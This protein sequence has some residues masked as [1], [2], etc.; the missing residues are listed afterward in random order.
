MIISKKRAL[1]CVTHHR[2][3]CSEYRLQEAEQALRI[4]RTWGAFDEE[5]KWPAGPALK[6]S[7]VIELC[8]K[9]LRCLRQE[10]FDFRK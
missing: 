8:D 1:R 4:I 9:A 2:C 3:D 6:P 5:G 10:V 7:H